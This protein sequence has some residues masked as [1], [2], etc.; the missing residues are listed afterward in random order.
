MNPVPSVIGVACEALNCTF[1]ADLCFHLLD[2]PT[3]YGP[4]GARVSKRAR[5]DGQGVTCRRF[6]EGKC[7][8]LQAGTT[9]GD[10]VIDPPKN[11]ALTIRVLTLTTERYPSCPN[12]KSPAQVLFYQSAAG[13]T[14]SDSI[15]FTVTFENGEKQTHF[16]AIT[17]TKEGQASTPEQL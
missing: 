5:F 3:G 14:G 17:V 11:G 6:R 2:Q 9:T 13:Y 10:S 15:S 7:Q 12:L 1:R 8:R 16:I 4:R